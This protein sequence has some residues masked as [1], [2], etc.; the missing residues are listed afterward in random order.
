MNNVI[1]LD[2]SISTYNVSEYSLTNQDNYK[3]NIS[4]SIGE[5]VDKYVILILEY[6]N[7]ITE[8]VSIKSDMYYK[9]VFLRGLDTISHVFKFI[10]LYTK[11]LDLAYYH[12]QKAFYFYVEFITQI[13]DD[14]HSFLQLSSRDAILFV[15]KRTIFEINYEQR[16]NLQKI[17]AESVEKINSLQVYTNIFKSVVEYLLHNPE[18]KFTTKNE[19]IS[20]YSKY[21]LSI[22]AKLQAGNLSK[23]KLDL[24]TMFIKCLLGKDIHLLFYFDLILC[25]I[26]KVSKFTEKNK[27]KVE[28]V[29]KNIYSTELSNMI[30]SNEEPTQIIKWVF[31]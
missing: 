30:M 21:F 6:M 24:F 19:F 16:K 2:P 8:N 31:V 5:I 22:C 18:Y 7:F 10:L 1:K 25:F 28:C 13:T 29:K 23:T 11:N 17:H 27:L 26:K 3:D 14:Q 15:Y 12:S 20:K 4:N 9:F